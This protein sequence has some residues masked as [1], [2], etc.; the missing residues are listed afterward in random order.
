MG[1][2]INKTLSRWD[3]YYDVQ[4]KRVGLLLKSVNHLPDLEAVVRQHMVNDSLVSL[5]PGK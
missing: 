2:G 3:H 5:Y 1:F 4:Q